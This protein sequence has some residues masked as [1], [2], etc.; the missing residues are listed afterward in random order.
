[1]CVVVPGE[2]D[3]AVN[4]NAFGRSAQIS[5]RRR[6]LGQAG[7]RWPLGIV[8]RTSLSRAVSSRLRKLDIEQHV[9]AFVL[10]SL[11]RTYF[12]AELNSHLRIVHRRI[13]H[14]LRTTH[15]FVGERDSCLVER[16]DERLRAVL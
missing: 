5:F 13:E 8:H 14:R 15:H 16:T 9:S 3:A 10:D 4:L 11:K 7:K 1:M 6:S 12:S 2:A